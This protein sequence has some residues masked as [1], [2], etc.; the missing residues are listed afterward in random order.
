MILHDFQRGRLP[1]F[2][3]PPKSE[4]DSKT[5]E[6][7]TKSKDTETNSEVPHV[8][9]QNFQSLNVV[10]EFQG[11]D[12]QTDI[13]ENE[14]SCEVDNQEES[15]ISDSENEDDNTEDNSNTET[16]SLNEENCETKNDICSEG[17][18]NELIDT[19]LLDALSSEEKQ[20]LKIKETESKGN[21]CLLN[22]IMKI[23]FCAK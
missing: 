23:L 5:D 14:E 8:V 22:S 6:K 4:E 2:V 7:D 13:T 20:F 19:S 12:L 15:D 1:Y 10:P 9:K 11:D 18:D 3:P 21:C 17:D 16:K